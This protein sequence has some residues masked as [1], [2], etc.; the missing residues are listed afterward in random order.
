MIKT[1]HPAIAVATNW[2]VLISASLFVLFIVLNFMLGCET[3][4]QALWTKNNSCIYP[5]D[6]LSI[7]IPPF[8]S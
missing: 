7:F 4:D 6:F 8:G 5:L 3:W 2:V 1:I